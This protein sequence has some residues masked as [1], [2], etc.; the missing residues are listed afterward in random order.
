MRPIWAVL[1]L[2]AALWAQ[3]SPAVVLRCGRAAEPVVVDGSLDDS[4]W[5]TA[6]VS[7]MDRREQLHPGYAAAWTGPDDLSARVRAV[8][9]HSHLYLA[10]E[11]RDDILLHE[12]GRAWWAG[13]S[14]E[15]F[16][17]ADLSGSEKA[18]DAYSADDFQ[19]FLLPFHHGAGRRW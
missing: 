12:A 6:P 2:G 17:D 16:V 15:V 13:D 9:S 19:L 18:D 3:E 5:L 1:V 14:I 11:V 7:T 8:L 10:F 4:A